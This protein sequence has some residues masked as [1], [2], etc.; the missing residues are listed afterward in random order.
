MPSSPTRPYLAFVR[1]TDEPG[2][3]VQVFRA[4][5]DDPLPEQEE[6]DLAKWFV[7]ANREGA[8]RHAVK[9]LLPLDFDPEREELRLC[10][11]SQWT[12]VP[13]EVSTNARVSVG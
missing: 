3:F 12:P 11:L 13:F 4:P 6:G 1:D 2:A 10:P 9:Y 7:A 5:G 8:I